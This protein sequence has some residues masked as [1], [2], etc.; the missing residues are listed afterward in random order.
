MEVLLSSFGILLPVAVI[1]LPF[2]LF[3]WRLLVQRR[4]RTRPTWIAASTAGIDVGA[5]L[6]AAL[7]LA[8]TMIPVAGG[9]TSSLHLVPGSDIVT[10]FAD[11]GALW[12]I[13]G[14]LVLLAPLGALVPLRV[15]RLH[16]VARVAWAAFVA[17]GAIE[18]TQFVLHVGRVTSTD[19]VLLNTLGAAAG[20]TLS[21]GWKRDHEVLAIPAPRRPTRE[22]GPVRV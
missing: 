5:V 8:L 13:A 19:D 21:C 10:E 14:N 22:G 4:R 7:V 16:S 11:D 6:L 1:V 3:T 17:S 15:T 18:L 2:A 20:A 12:Q 9:H